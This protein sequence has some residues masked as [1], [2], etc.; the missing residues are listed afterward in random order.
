MLLINS[1]SVIGGSWLGFYAFKVLR[2]REKPSQN[3]W[4]EIVLDER[5][6]FLFFLGSG[7]LVLRLLS[8]PLFYLTLQSF[9]KHIQGAMCIYGVTMVLPHLFKFIK[10][11][12][13]LLLFFCGQWLIWHSLSRK[14]SERSVLLKKLGLLFVLFNTLLSKSFK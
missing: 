6:R 1:A 7:L 2:N 5:I 8:Y 10:I 9:V 14:E 11:E 4:E 12:K 3:Q 13:P